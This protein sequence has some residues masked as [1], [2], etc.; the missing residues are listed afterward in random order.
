LVGA[1]PEIWTFRGGVDTSWE[2]EGVRSGPSSVWASSASLT[3]GIAD[4]ENVDLWRLSL[5]AS[6][7]V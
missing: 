5:P 4:M 2:G 6:K 1:E 7:W 3:L